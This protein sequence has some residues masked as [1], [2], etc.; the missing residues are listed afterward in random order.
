MSSGKMSDN[1]KRI[2]A[3]IKADPVLARYKIAY[4]LK[5][6]R[7]VS[8]LQRKF[9]AKVRHDEL[10]AFRESCKK[11]GIPQRTNENIPIRRDP[12][13]ARQLPV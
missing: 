1:A 8:F 13:V 2:R 9:W 7:R 11:L 10:A 6:N 4:G 3:I 12:D 5:V